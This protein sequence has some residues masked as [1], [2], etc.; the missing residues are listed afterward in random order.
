MYYSAPFHALPVTLPLFSVCQQTKA[1]MEL[2]PS[3][4]F[5]DLF[6]FE[7]KDKQLEV[8]NHVIENKVSSVFVSLPTGFGKSMC[9]VAPP[10]ILDKVRLPHGCPFDPKA[11]FYNTKTS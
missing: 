6:N 9:Y 2:T 10:V 5:Y 11:T 1:V 7:I 3:M 4:V 8:L